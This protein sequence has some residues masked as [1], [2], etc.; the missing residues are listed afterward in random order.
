VQRMRID[1]E[2]LKDRRRRGEKKRERKRK[3]V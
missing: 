2:R 3:R 1:Y